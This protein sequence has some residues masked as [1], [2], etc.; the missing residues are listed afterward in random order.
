MAKREMY[1]SKKMSKKANDEV[2]C[3][4]HIIWEIRSYFMKLGI[5]A[6]SRVLY[7]QGQINGGFF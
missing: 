3:Q 2:K 1:K 4:S 6:R 5:K 7:S